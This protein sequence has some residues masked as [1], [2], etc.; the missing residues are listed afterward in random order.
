M[1]NRSLKLPDDLDASIIEIAR[2]ERRSIH[3][4]ILVLLESA[5]KGNE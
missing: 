4:Q 2:R 5:V 3:A 1:A